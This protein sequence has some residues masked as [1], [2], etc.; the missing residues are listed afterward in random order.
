MGISKDAVKIGYS[1]DFTISALAGRTG[2]SHELSFILNLDKLDN[3][4][5]RND[6]RD[7]NDC[8]KLFR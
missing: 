1:Y 3:N 2:G 6:A 4:R 7:M 5:R 8:F